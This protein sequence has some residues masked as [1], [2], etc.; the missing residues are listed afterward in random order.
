MAHVN[1]QLGHASDRD[2]RRFLKSV[3]L[4]GSLAAGGISLHEIRPELT[5]PN[6]PELASMGDAVAGD[7]T[8]ALN[9]ELLAT[10]QTALIERATRSTAVRERGF[11]DSGPRADFKPIAAAGR[12]IYDHLVET[13]FFEST[14]DNLPAFTPDYLA[15]C[16]EAVVASERLATSLEAIG[17]TGRE[18][19]DRI[20][21]VIG[22]AEQLKR[23]HWLATD[24]LTR[25]QFE[26]ADAVPPMTR[27]ATGGALLWLEH[28]DDH[29]WKNRTLLTEEML[30]DAVWHARS[31]AAGLALLTEGA[32]A[33]A[34]GSPDLTDAE[35][36]AVLS[37]GIAVQA[38]AQYLLSA[39]VYW[40]T[41]DDRAARRTDLRVVTD[42]ER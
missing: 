37:T 11:P 29:V 2:R 8:G 42:G 5:V 3:G 24:A 28:L 21:T 40:V 1:T 4:T 15:T 10:N 31:M 12:P 14:T 20:A 39:D 17:I 38:I 13:G 34:D 19:V 22:N 23:Y 6:R 30:D 25:E 16:V 33:I 36:G 26:F 18:G 35:L 41:D 27:A 32:K 7:L 9:A